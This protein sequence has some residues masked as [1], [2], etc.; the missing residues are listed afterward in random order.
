MSAF[1]SLWMGQEKDH[2]HPKAVNMEKWTVYKKVLVSP[3]NTLSIIFHCIT[4]VKVFMAV[5]TIVIFHFI[6]ITHY[7]STK[8]KF[9]FFVIFILDLHFLSVIHT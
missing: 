6:C 8:Y 3:A 4:P 9:L 2:P 7:Y 5:V 1:Y